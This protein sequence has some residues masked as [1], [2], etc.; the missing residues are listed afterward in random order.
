MLR[1]AKEHDAYNIGIVL[2]RLFERD[3]Q[4]RGP[5]NSQR[6]IRATVAFQRCVVVLTNLS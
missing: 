5:T 2:L 3:Y 1:V 6:Y 4:R